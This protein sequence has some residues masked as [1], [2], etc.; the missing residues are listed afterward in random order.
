MRKLGD[1]SANDFDAVFH[2]AR[3]RM[4]AAGVQMMS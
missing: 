3:L 1:V 2:A 4:Q